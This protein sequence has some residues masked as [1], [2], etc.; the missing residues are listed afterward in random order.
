MAMTKALII[1]A[2]CF[3]ETNLRNEIKDA[4]RSGSLV[5]IWSKQGQLDSELR[6]ANHRRYVRYATAGR[7]YCVC[8]VCVERKTN[9]LRSN[10]NL[11]SN[12]AHIVALALV[13]GANV[14]ATDDTHLTN[15][16]SG[17]NQ[18]ERSSNCRKRQGRRIPRNVIQRSTRSDIVVRLLNGATARYKHCPCQCEQ[19]GC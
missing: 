4:I 6:R 3:S 11:T 9:H 2:N 17:C 15:D 18:I 14:L 12:D 16:F 1:D 8:N 7:F 13:S 19:T 10:G 5:P